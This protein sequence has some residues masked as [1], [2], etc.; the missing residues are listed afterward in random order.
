LL[1]L[2]YND[3]NIMNHSYYFHCIVKILVNM[4]IVYLYFNLFYYIFLINKCSSL[5]YMHNLNVIYA[6]ENSILL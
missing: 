6:R 5:I 1:K 3:S 2:L 4:N